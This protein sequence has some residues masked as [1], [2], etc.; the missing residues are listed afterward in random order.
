MVGTK[1]SR[2]QLVASLK[3]YCITSQRCLTPLSTGKRHVHQDNDRAVSQKMGQSLGQ[4][5][6]GIP[7]HLSQ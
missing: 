5:Y 4:A 6:G 3:V 7:K 1:K 2:A